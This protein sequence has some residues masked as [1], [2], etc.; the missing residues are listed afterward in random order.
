MIKLYGN[1]Y[2]RAN[3][4]RWALEESGA[5]YEEETVALG[6]GGTRSA[7]FLEINPNGH[8]SV[9]DDGGLV[10]FE[11]VPISLYVAKKYSPTELHVQSEPDEGRLLQ[12]SVWAITELEKHIETASLHVTWLPPAARSAD[13]AASGQVR[14]ARCLTILAR[15]LEPTGY[16]V[17]E[18]FTVADLIVTEVITNL[19]HTGVPLDQFPAVQRCVRKN[20]SRP[21]A[22]K[23]F[24]EDIIRPFLA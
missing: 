15:A 1:P 10:L 19:V 2:S 11:S 7:R 18:R 14:V 4:V 23:A 22:R 6:A 21:A 12:W 16:L 8:V 13:K 9:I 17:A 5:A 24:A 20:L 3:R